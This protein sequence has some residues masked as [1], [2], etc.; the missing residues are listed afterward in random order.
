MIGMVD[1]YI[2][3]VAGKYMRTWRCPGSNK[4]YGYEMLQKSRVK[5]GKI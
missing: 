3:N 5:S 1:E 2:G 4:S